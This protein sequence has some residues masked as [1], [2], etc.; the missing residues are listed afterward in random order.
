MKCPLC[1]TIALQTITLEEHLKAENCQKC[2]G[3]W[4]SSERYWQW[5]DIHGDILPEKIPEIHF[6]TKDSQQA[7]LCPEC[8]RILVKYKV[9][10]GVNF[11]LDHCSNCNGVWFD[12]NEWESLKERNLHDEVHYIF[13]KSWQKQILKEEIESNLDTLYRNKFGVEDYLNLR[14]FKQ[15]LDKHPQRLALLAYLNDENPY[16]L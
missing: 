16:E 13:T 7:K 1:K 8:N 14:K 3:S 12:K 4:I 15:W 6:D 5:L 2:Q 10:H 9:G 11:F